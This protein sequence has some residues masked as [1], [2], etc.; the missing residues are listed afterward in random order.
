MYS[1]QQRNF[2]K[3]MDAK[4][5]TLK[6][7]HETLAEETKS[8]LEELKQNTAVLNADRP[9]LNDGVP[10]K[11]QEQLNELHDKH[12]AEIKRL[13]GEIEMQKKTKQQEQKREKEQNDK[14]SFLSVYDFADIETKGSGDCKTKTSG[15]LFKKSSVFLSPRPPQGT[16]NSKTLFARRNI[17]SPVATVLPQ[18]QDRGQIAVV[19][20]ERSTK[21][22]QEIVSETVR[23]TVAN[24]T[25]RNVP[26]SSSFIST[27][28][29]RNTPVPPQINDNPPNTNVTASTS[30]DESLHLPNYSSA[31]Q[32]MKK[33]GRKRKSKKTKTSKISTQNPK[34]HTKRSQRSSDCFKTEEFKQHFPTERKAVEPVPQTKALRDVFNFT[35]VDSGFHCKPQS[36]G[37]VKAYEK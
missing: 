36:E 37:E 2:S 26:N 5:E 15:R 21:I 10:K 27:T 33:K 22:A 20:N 8:L 34:P 3:D 25:P 14:E 6:S 9:W 30:R 16:W 17:V 35:D 24:R 23:Q 7:G 13:E 19:S 18:R 12:Q 32:V 1:K 11:V 29:H 31:N 28:S 4:F